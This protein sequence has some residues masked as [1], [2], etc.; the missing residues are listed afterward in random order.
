MEK[1]SGGILPVWNLFQ[2]NFYGAMLTP[3]FDPSA[4]V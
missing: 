1:Q 3:L 4:L 2:R